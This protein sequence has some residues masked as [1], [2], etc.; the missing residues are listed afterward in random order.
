MP[1]K[2]TGT[3]VYVPARA[4]EVQGHYKVR[5]TC[6]NGSRPWIP[7]DPGPKSPQA[8]ARAKETAA[9]Y[10]ERA[11]I[12]GIVAVPGRK[13]VVLAP[14]DKETVE[15]WA[16]RW[17][18]QRE[19]RGF[20]S[21]GS[22]RGRLK[23]W[24]VPRF[25]GMAMAAVTRKDVEALVEDLDRRV[26]GGELAWKT[27]LNAW[28]LTSKM[29]ADAQRSKVLALRVRDDNPAADVTG[30]DRGARRSKA[31]VYP[32][33]FELLMACDDVP[34]RWR[35]LFAIST[36]LYVRAAELRAL[37]WADV[38]LD[39]RR[40]LVHRSA[41]P[42]G[43]PN[44]TKGDEAR[45]VPIEPALLPLLQAMHDEADGEGLV[46]ERMPPEEH[47]ADK[48]RGYLKRAGVKRAE[49][50]K[51]DRTRRQLRFHDLRATGLTW[52]A[53]RGDEPLKIMQAAGHKDFATTMQYIRTAEQLRAGFGEPFPPLPQSVLDGEPSFGRI[54]PGN[55][56]GR[57]FGAKYPVSQW[58][59]G[60]SNPRP[61]G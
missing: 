8:E 34:L 22:D 16:D 57:Y 4:G 43:T 32:S 59:Q 50:F 7:L 49:L 24:I 17:C 58:V 39:H 37:E 9:H 12:E 27:A 52:R 18:T 53:V 35:R 55:V 41:A 61:T 21:V 6:P 44:T 19:A 5:I 14:R 29:F 10:S 30:P 38:D 48:L 33:E 3:V 42:D 46:V 25:T 1:R 56:P 13:R 40:V 26:Q 54:V 60:D 11:K 31:F 47:L 45:P 15:D 2:A 36:Y 23:K 28:A 51:S 20:T